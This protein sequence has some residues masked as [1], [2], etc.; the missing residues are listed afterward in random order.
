[1][2]A[3]KSPSELKAIYPCILALAVHSTMLKLPCVCVAC[4]KPGNTGAIEQASQPGGALILADNHL[5]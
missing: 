4:V 2:V 3:D 5:H 1:M